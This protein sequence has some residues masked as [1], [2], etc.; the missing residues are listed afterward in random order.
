MTDFR[1]IFH[2]FLPVIFIS[3]LVVAASLRF[4]HLATLP[5]ALNRDEA[6]LAY[7]AFLLKETGK[8]E[9]QRSWPVA[10]ESFGDY[11]LPGYPLLIVA[12]FSFF[13][14]N[15]FAVRFPSALAG[16]LL[17]G[18]AYVFSR[19]VLHLRRGTSLIVMTLIAIQ[20]VFFFYS[21]MAWEAN[22]GLM[23]FVA[24]L[25]CLFSQSKQGSRQVIWDTVAGLLFVLAIFTYNTPLLLLP[26][27]GLALVFFRGLRMPKKWIAAGGMLAV[28]FI[29]G[30]L[31]FQSI[32]Q[33]KSAITIF[34]DEST[35]KQSVDYY[36][37]FSG[38]SQK[39]FGNRYVFFG[40]IMAENFIQS[41]SPIFLVQKGG[42][43]PWH[44]IPNYGHLYLASYLLGLLGI[45]Q[46]F[47]KLLKNTKQP[48]IFGRYLAV[49]ILFFTALIP[50]IITVDAPHAT[51]SLFFLFV[52]C[53]LSGLALEWLWQI[54]AQQNWRIFFVV[55][56]LLGLS[57]EVQKYYFAFFAKYPDQ[58]AEILQAGLGPKLQ[59]LE[60]EFADKSDQVAIVDPGGYLYVRAAWEMRMPAEQFFS[61]VTRHLPDR[62]GFKY[63]Y[64]VG[65]YRFIAQPADKI[66]EDKRILEW[67]ALE[68]QWEI[69]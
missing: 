39:V 48:L 63:G 53:C 19:N 26:F 10:L 50:S 23:F 20:P 58:S 24:G 27:T 64:R 16:V 30:F 9:W 46:I 5:S 45:A 68:K 56:L 38:I 67:N 4:Y 34:S 14:F 49:L 7:N 17:V 37:S 55:L 13:G 51:R 69:R 11:K 52:F 32:S 59:Q 47:W 18:L 57:I 3:I 54:F 41:F 6:A 66:E 42:G 44:S 22:V 35:W 2:K 43:H 36:Q 21:R 33:Q 29:G 62:I 28:I 61:T 1:S 65:R 12:S 40:K 15:D 25:C 8:D 60:T 31:L